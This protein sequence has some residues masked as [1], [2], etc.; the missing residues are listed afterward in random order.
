MNAFCA[1]VNFDARILLS[2][3]S[4][5]PGYRKL[6]AETIQFV[7]G[8]AL[9]YNALRSNF[10]LAQGGV[11]IAL[12]ASNVTVDEIR[13]EVFTNLSFRASPKLTLESGLALEASRIK[14]AG[15]ADNQQTILILKPSATARYAFREGL[16]G[17]LSLERRA[18]QLDFGDFAASAE[19]ADERQFGGNPDLQP[20]KT[21]RAATSL[22]WRKSSG[23]ALNITIF[24]EWRE[25][26][27]EQIILPSGAAGLGNAGKAEVSGI[28]SS[29][30]LPLP[31][32][33]PGARLEGTVNIADSRFRD[34][35]TGQTR[36]VN[37]LERP[38]IDISF[39][40]DLP[41]MKLSWGVDYASPTLTERFFVAEILADRR[42]EIWNAF[43]ETTHIFGFTTRL[44]LSNL[45]TR[46]FPQERRLFSP[47]RS[48][49]L[50]GIE[51]V[52]R[53]RGSFVTL[54]ISDTF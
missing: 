29:F 54:T 2:P 52:D 45:G 39:R 44:K 11:P 53:T 21:W 38:D 23:H 9:A 10:E 26:I 6:Q 27:L 46:D 4:Q 43:V 50:T 16:S 3:P 25:D 51:R 49:L 28:E 30:T 36:Q 1:S 13:S 7:G 12:P 33:I 40:Q 20:D 37:A 8:R 17:R 15:D 24:H 5:V 35:V 14:V 41:T 47:D 22:D 19:L 42:G 48:G 34:P 18:G 31:A 32:L